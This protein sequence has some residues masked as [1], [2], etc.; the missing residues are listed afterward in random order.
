MNVSDKD[1]FTSLRSE[2]VKSNWKGSVM[3]DWMRT[4]P[5]DFVWWEYTKIMANINIYI[6]N[7]TIFAAWKYLWK[8]YHVIYGMPH[9]YCTTFSPGLAATHL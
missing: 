2:K 3:A 9:P 4:T 7:Y 6:I 1:I 5:G 8:D